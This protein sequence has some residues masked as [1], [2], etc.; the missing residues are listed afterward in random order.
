MLKKH[1]VTK[2][3]GTIVR[4]ASEVVVQRTLDIHK[5]D[6]IGR[7]EEITAQLRSEITIHLIEEIKRRLDGR[8]LNGVKFDVYIYKKRNEEKLTGA[9]LAGVLEIEANGKKTTKAYLAQAKVCQIRKEDR[10]GN[11]VIYCYDKNIKDQA[12]KMLSI[13]SDSFFFLYTKQGI[14]MIP[15]VEVCSTCKNSI[16]TEELYYHTFGVFYEEFFKCFIGD[17]KIAPIYKDVKTLA[18]FAEEYK[19][20]NVL[21]IKATI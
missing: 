21:Y 16:N 8:K 18:T 5:G 19:V 9:E 10:F 3:L 12:S 11:P 14:Y 6:I 13:T 1:R 4:E 2:R 20:N 7:E 15:A 17:H